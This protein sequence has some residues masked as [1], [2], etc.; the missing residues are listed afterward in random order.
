MHVRQSSLHLCR[1]CRV[2]P[3]QQNVCIQALSTPLSLENLHFGYSLRMVFDDLFSRFARG[4]NLE[5]F[6]V[7][8][9]RISLQFI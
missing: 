2:E 4:L 3:K 7:D 9:G 1:R 8:F 5:K 6:L